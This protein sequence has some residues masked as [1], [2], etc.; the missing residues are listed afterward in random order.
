M[1][2]Y[3]IGSTV[4]SAVLGVLFKSLTIGHTPLPSLAA[5]RW[6]FALSGVAGAIAPAPCAALA[7]QARGRARRAETAARGPTALPGATR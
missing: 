1:V 7:A 2:L 4:G 6:G 3:A 5:F